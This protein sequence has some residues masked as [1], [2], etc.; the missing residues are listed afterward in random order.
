MAEHG[1]FAVAGSG[2]GIAGS[3]DAFHFVS[4]PITEQRG[5]DV[6]IIARV[7]STESF[8]PSQ[9][10]LMVRASGGAGAPHVTVP[11][12]MFAFS[13]T[14][15]LAFVR[16][17]TPGGATTATLGPA[18]G[19]PVW[20]R[21]LVSNGVVSAYYRA[22][23]M[24]RGDCSAAKRCRSVRATRRAWLCPVPAMARS[25]A[26]RSTTSPANFVRR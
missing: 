8:G 26:A 23:R 12:L 19:D 16:R 5:Q 13:R 4:R 14:A 6:E 17:R 20:L 25:A 2:A 9:A 11:V 10:G 1:L 3:A 15:G 7:A 21:F 24:N 22:S 18:F